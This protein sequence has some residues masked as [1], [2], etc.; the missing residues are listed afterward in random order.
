V[1]YKVP[2]AF[3]SRFKFRELKKSEAGL[4]TWSFVGT[5]GNLIA[6][7]VEG[8]RIQRLADQAEF[9]SSVTLKG[10][11]QVEVLISEK[12]FGQYIGPEVPEEPKRKVTV[13]I[14]DDGQNEKK[15]KDPKQPKQ[16]VQLGENEIS[17][18]LL[19]EE[20]DTTPQKLRSK[21]RKNG[22]Q[23]SGPRW[24]WDKESEELVK[25]RS[26]FK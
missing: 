20:L 9:T 25:I 3:E 11:D 23:K 8:K 17:I 14:Y 6:D 21:L 15:P 7:E 16:K 26:Y 19:A 18:E 5:P 24:S 2:F 13:K 22:H 4:K 10:I 1:E 12:E